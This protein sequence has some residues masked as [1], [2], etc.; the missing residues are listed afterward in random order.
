MLPCRD[1]DTL[2]IGF[3]RDPWVRLRAFHPRFHAFF[4]LQRAALLETELVCDARLVEKHLKSKFS[5][6][7]TISPLDVRQS[8][9]GKFEWFRGICPQVLAELRTRSAELGFV[10][11]EPLTFWLRG[12]WQQNVD[13]I[14]DW[15]RREYDRIELFHFNANPGVGDSR[16]HNFRN[17]LEAWESIGMDLDAVLDESVLSWYRFGFAD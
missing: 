3:A 11:H 10:L 13:R 1:E 12:Q 8:A 17:L 7:A 5:A 2:K 9:G 16:E 6:H 4:D 15:S 14:I